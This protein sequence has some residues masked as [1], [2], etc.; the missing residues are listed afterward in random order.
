MNKTFVVYE[1]KYGATK[2]TAKNI[3]M[4]LGPAEYCTTKEWKKEYENCQSIIIGTSIYN[5]QVNQEIYGFVEKNKNWLKNSKVYLFCVCLMDQGGEKYL[6]PLE[7]ILGK[8]VVSKKSF[9]GRI[10]LNKLDTK[11]FWALKKF[12]QTYGF[13]FKNIDIY[14]IREVI[15]YGI[16]IKEERDFQVEM[17]YE[18]LKMYVEQFLLEHSSCTLCSGYENSVRAT[19]VDYTYK[20]SN[21]YVLSEG[22]IKFTNLLFNEQVS[23]AVYEVFTGY[24]NLAG[25]QITGRAD[26]V[27]NESEEYKLFLKLK[28]INID[29][30]PAPL[31]LIKIRIEK[32]EFLWFKFKNMGYGI[33]QYFEF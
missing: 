5:E 1:S 3:A 27:E 29:K 13:E 26:I 11:D 19:P 6:K 32:I 10:E 14:N 28:E 21:M 20:E 7:D 12:S 8:C 31:H 4:I 30:L 24:N 22:G 18:E 23:L 15:N 33:K 2:Q 16:A 25:M 9:G 17:P